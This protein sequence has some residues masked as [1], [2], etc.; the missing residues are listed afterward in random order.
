VALVG[1][2]VAC[3]RLPAGR[4]YLSL[5]LSWLCYD[6]PGDSSVDVVLTVCRLHGVWLGKPFET[7]VL[8]EC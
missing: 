7:S 6:N 8:F 2:R 3:A 4:N 5:S 1:W